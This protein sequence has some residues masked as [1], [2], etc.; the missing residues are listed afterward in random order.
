[1]DHYQPIPGSINDIDDRIDIP[2]K[3][4]FLVR[5]CL[6]FLGFPFDAAANHRRCIKH[7]ETAPSLVDINSNQVDTCEVCDDVGPLTQYKGSSK[8]SRLQ[9]VC[10]PVWLCI[11]STLPIVSL[12]HK[13]YQRWGNEHFTLYILSY[14]CFMGPVAAMA[15]YRLVAFCT[16]CRPDGT[17]AIYALTNIHVL[18]LLKRSD[19]S[20]STLAGYVYYLF[21]LVCLSLNIAFEFSQIFTGCPSIDYWGVFYF[22]TEMLAFFTFSSFWYIVLL[23]RRALE[24]DLKS[25]AS[26]CKKHYD[27]NAICRQRIMESFVEFSRLNN[28]VSG[29]IVCQV[30]VNAF[31]LSCHLYWNYAVYSGKNHIPSATLINSLI[32][33]E[34]LAYFVLPFFAVGWFN[35]EYIWKDFMAHVEYLQSGNEYWPCFKMIKHLQPAINNITITILFSVLTVFL[36]LQFTTQYAEYWEEDSVC[37][38]LSDVYNM[39]GFM[40]LAVAEI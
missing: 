8:Q 6:A 25:V 20:N 36:S 1:M 21:A 23:L 34:I 13:T 27:N 40:N 12:F 38:K 29:W 39:T 31:K 24:N 10:R 16:A 33:V 32:S 14:F 19:V 15:I 26:F 18:G 28:F 2:R 4:P 35:I 5:L 37:Y 7:T 11:L 22:L 3:A 9:R 17:R 30:N